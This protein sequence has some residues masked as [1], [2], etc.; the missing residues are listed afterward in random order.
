MALAYHL[1]FPCLNIINLLLPTFSKF[2]FNVFSFLYILYLKTVNHPSTVHFDARHQVKNG[3]HVNYFSRMIFYRCMVIFPHCFAIPTLC[4]NIWHMFGAILC[5]CHL[6]CISLFMC[7]LTKF[8][9][10]FELKYTL[11][12]F[13]S[14]LNG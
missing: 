11:L 1:E 6:T 9:I 7:H 8:I 5:L 4:F 2:N 13:P 3:L 12:E 14:W 10:T